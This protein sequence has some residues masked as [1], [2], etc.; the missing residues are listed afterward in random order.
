MNKKLST[1]EKVRRMI[2]QGHSNKAIIDK[3]GVKP[4]IVYNMRYQVNKARGLGAIG[5]APIKPVEGIGTPPKKRGPRVKAQG[6]GITPT[7]PVTHPAMTEPLVR[8]EPYMP[9]TMIDPEPT[10]FDKVRE[11]FRNLMRALGGR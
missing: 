6:T 2:D 9:I 10:I 1:A 11:R 4:Q 5:A 3:L 8:V 7:P